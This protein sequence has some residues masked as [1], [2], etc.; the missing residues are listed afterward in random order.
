MMNLF[1]KEEYKA[2]MMRVNVIN[3]YFTYDLTACAQ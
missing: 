3:I 2:V 1:W